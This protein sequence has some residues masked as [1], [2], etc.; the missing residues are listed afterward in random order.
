MRKTGG[1]A[2]ALVSSENSHNII[3]FIIGFGCGSWYSPND[4]NRNIQD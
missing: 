4:Y 1:G 2:A 3:E